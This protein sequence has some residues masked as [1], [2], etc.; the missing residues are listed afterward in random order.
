MPLENDSS[1]KPVNGTLRASFENVT[2]T[3]TSR[4]APGKSEV[5]LAPAE[6]A[7]LTCRIRGSGGRMATASRSC[8]R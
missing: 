5:K 7:Q 6:F 1:D 2:V 4:V 8:T 3:K